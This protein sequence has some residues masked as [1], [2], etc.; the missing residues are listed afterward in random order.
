M[1]EEEAVN[2]K[3]H[4]QFPTVRRG[5]PHRWSRFATIT[6]IKDSKLNSSINKKPLLLQTLVLLLGRASKLTEKC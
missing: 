4:L 1:L 6:I 2:G 3:T 5:T